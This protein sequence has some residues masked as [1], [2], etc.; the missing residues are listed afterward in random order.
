[1]PNAVVLRLAE[2]DATQSPVPWLK[3]KVAI[4]GRPTAYVC[5]RGRCELPTSDPGRLRAQLAERRRPLP[6]VSGIDA[7]QPGRSLRP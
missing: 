7:I 4:D 5:E 2:R 6:R 3:G 1:M